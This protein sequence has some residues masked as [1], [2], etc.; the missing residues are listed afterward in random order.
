MNTYFIGVGIYYY[1]PDM[2]M[3]MGICIGITL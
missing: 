2:V 3:D 1:Y